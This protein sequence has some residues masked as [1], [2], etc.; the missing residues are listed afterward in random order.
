MRRLE[1]LILG[2]RALID[3]ENNWH[4]SMNASV[5]EVLD[6]T[7]YR[8]SQ[9]R[10]DP[11]FDDNWDESEFDDLAWKTF[12]LSFDN[13]QLTSSLA[14][15]AGLRY[16]HYEMLKEAIFGGKTSLSGLFTQLDWQL[17]SSLM[18]GLGA[19]IESWK[20]WDG[21][22][23]ANG[24]L[25]EHEDRSDS[26]VSP[27][28]NLLY[29]IGENKSLQF[30][31]AKAY[32]YPI[33]EELFNNES[34]LNALSISNEGLAPEDG[35]FYNLGFT[36]K[37]AASSVTLNV[38]YDQVANTIYSHQ[39]V[40]DNISVRTFLPIDEVTTEGAELI[41][42]GK[43]IASLPINLRLNLTYTDAEITKNTVGEFS[44]P[45]L[46]SPDDWVGK[47]FPR[48]PHWR[49]NMLATYQVNHQWDISGGFRFASN[50]YGDPDNGDTNEKVFGA[51]DAYDFVNLKT[52]YRLN[53]HVK[54]AFGIDN[55]MNKIA[56]VHHPWPGRTMYVEFGLSY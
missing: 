13:M 7:T 54:M 39:K 23:Q 8:T 40:I 42:H 26:Q 9:N 20:S 15:K 27:K 12:D 38:F 35:N 53:D 43:N 24:M 56:Y 4:L 14:F 52:A 21:F 6:D 47:R 44:D 37:Y 25:D 49:L 55:V 32:R 46:N 3:F 28:F 36:K 10:L 30:S 33:V 31:A 34:S 16:D 50:A 45:D 48:I 17:N 41:W 51:M 2:S 1:S 18:L 29:E 5:F 19:R 22:R 11:D